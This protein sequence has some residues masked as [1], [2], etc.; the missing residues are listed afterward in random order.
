MSSPASGRAAV[1]VS[2]AIIGSL[3]CCALP[4]KDQ[5]FAR[6]RVRADAPSSGEYEGGGNAAGA[7]GTAAEFS[8]LRGRGGGCFRGGQQGEGT[9]LRMLEMEL[10]GTGRRRH[11]GPR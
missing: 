6:A 5:R 7:I 11:G 1:A 4:R 3:A 8:C 2:C 10:P 9:L